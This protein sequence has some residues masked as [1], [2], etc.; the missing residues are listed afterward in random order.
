MK[1]TIIGNCGPYPQVNGAPCS[2][3]LLEDKDTKIVMDMGTGSMAVLREFVDI[4]SVDAFF[5][6]HFHFDHVSDFLS[7]RYYLETHGIH[8]KV[9][10]KREETAIFKCLFDNS[11][12]IEVLPIGEDVIQKLNHLSLSFALL[13]HPKDNFAIKVNNGEKVFVYSGDTTDNPKLHDFCKDANVV[14]LDCV[15]PSGARGPHAN[16]DTAITITKE[17]GAK[18]LATHIQP[19]LDNP[20]IFDNIP[21][22]EVAKW[23]QTYEI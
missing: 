17:T 14:L 22:V 6:S 18:I 12:L 15:K 13:P 7:F 8:I 5:F 16:I 19:E 1:V 9:F 11:Y 3:Y 4:K 21:N 20:E 10:A 2:C 23:K